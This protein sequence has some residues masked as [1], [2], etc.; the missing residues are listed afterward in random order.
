MLWHCV[1]V[2]FWKTHIFH[3]HDFQIIRAESE[4]EARSKYDE[5][6]NCNYYYGN[7]I[8]Q[9]IEPKDKKEVVIKNRKS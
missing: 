3:Y 6:N 1:V 4:D 7:V 8:G 9:V 5:L 2:E